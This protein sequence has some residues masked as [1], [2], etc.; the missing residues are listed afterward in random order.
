MTEA[1]RAPIAL[2]NTPPSATREVSSESTPPRPPP[3]PQPI[4]SPTSLL[5]NRVV[6]PGMTLPC[7]HGLGFEEPARP[8]SPRAEPPNVVEDAVDARAPSPDRR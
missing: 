7:L 4:R 8:P 2:S 5:V 3:A 6:R 1:H